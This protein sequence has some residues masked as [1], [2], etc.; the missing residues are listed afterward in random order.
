[1][2]QMFSEIIEER[3]LEGKKRVEFAK[4]IQELTE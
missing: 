3:P 4:N 1:M 2:L